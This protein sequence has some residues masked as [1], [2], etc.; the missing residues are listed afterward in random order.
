L[1][2]HAACYNDKISAYVAANHPCASTSAAS[3]QGTEPIMS[4]LNTSVTSASLWSF[5][6]SIG[7]RGL[8]FVFFILLSRELAPSALGLMALA[9]SVSFLVDTLCEAGLSDALVRQTELSESFINAVTTIQGGIGMLFLLLSFV[10]GAPIAH[11]FHEPLLTYLLPAVMTASLCSAL[12]LTPLAML[13]RSMKFREITIRNFGGTFI[14]GVVG[15]LMARNGYGV[16][17]LVALQVANA[18]TAAII[19]YMVAGRWPKPSLNL[20]VLAP[21]AAFAWRMTGTKLLENSLSRL[22]QFLV[23]SVFGV[24]ALGLYALAGKLCETLFS[25][26]CMPFADVFLSKLTKYIGDRAQFIQQFFTFIHFAALIGPITFAMAALF[27]NAFL[28]DLFGQQWR[29]AAPYIWI[30]LG[31]ATVQ[32]VAYVNSVALVALG[33]A[34][35]RLNM[36]IISIVMWAITIGILFSHGPLMAAVAWACRVSIIFPVQ[37]VFLKKE[38]EFSLA[39][40]WAAMQAGWL[41]AGASV[42]CY[43]ATT[44]ALPWTGH[45]LIA[46]ALALSI[47][48]AAGAL[49]IW[50]ASPIARS[51]LNQLLGVAM[52]RLPTSR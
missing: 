46:R 5:A 19:C 27:L 24:H 17:S 2:C 42:A 39:T 44:L 12:A 1:C 4:R 29:D 49:V 48:G 9:L 7:T 31:F 34:K 18:L 35:V 11:A 16:W 10:L 45:S 37:I 14:G 20:S 36:A 38:L 28:G 41:A 52:A 15:Y 43:A 51:K 25:V 3:D 13:K 23:G 8:S 30:M 47:S 32:S 33:L 50:Y 40:Y 6:N 21:V 22:D 26:A